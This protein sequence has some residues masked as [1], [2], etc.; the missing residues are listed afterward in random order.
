MIGFRIVSGF[1]RGEGESKERSVPKGG[2][3]ECVLGEEGALG[4][5]MRE[6]FGD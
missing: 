6:V 4:E 1:L 5:E 2:L 3:T